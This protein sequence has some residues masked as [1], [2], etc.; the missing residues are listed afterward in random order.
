[1]GRI[2]RKPGHQFDLHLVPNS[3][4]GSFTWMDLMIWEL[5]PFEMQVTYAN[6]MKIRGDLIN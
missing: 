5:V 6:F 2:P 1:M 3:I 4:S